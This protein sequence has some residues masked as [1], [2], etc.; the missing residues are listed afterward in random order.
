MFL[1]TLTGLA[2]AAL[3]TAAPGIALAQA[4]P[5]PASAA[6]PSPPPSP[7]ILAL[8]HQYMVVMHVEETNKQMIANIF[9]GM[10]GTAGSSDARTNA[11][12]EGVEAMITPMVE[13]L[14]SQME[15]IVAET[16]T[17]QELQ[18]MVDFYG[19]P[20]GQSVLQKI[21]LMTGKL[22]AASM[23]MMQEMAAKRAPGCVGASCPPK[24]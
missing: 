11:A 23:G 19:S 3:L 22:S 18:A 8:A 24:P 10:R 4:A 20:I 6:T 2:L 7:R 17:E 13:K 12:M 1:R 16:F 21:P 5:G 9:A 15:P 14:E